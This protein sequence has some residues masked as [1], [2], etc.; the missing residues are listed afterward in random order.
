MAT[1]AELQTDVYAITNRPDLVAETKLAV[2]AATLKAHQS[3]FYFKDLF[4]TG[5]QF[6]TADYTQQLDVKSIIPRFRTLK[7]IRRYDNTG[8]GKAAEY[9]PILTPNELLDSYGVDKQ[10]VAYVAG[11]TL[12]IKSF[13]LLQ[14]ALLGV[15]LNPDITD[16]NYTSWVATDHPYCIEF[17]AARLVFKQ[18]GF[19]EQAAAFEKLAMEQFAELKLNN[20]QAVGY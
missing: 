11:T 14:Y 15:Y 3:D 20:I 7:Y 4:E 18:I 13:N 5:I 17:E 19:D 10:S 8:T 2:K 12:N 16:L 6:S 9:Y 1:F